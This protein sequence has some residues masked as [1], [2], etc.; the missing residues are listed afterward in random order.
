MNI[1]RIT[2]YLRLREQLTESE[3]QL[4][5][6]FAGLSE[7][8][9]GLLVESLGPV[10]RVAKK[11]ASK[12][13]RATGLA[14]QLSGAAGIQRC[15]ATVDDKPCGEPQGHALHE[16]KSYGNYHPFKSGAAS[17]GGRSRPSRVGESS[18]SFETGKDDASSAA[19]AGSGD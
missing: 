12:S 19:G 10:K 7:T 4:A 1:R 11:K 15:D 8:D 13:K 5:D 2:Q 18:A 9:R 17:V 3:L 14:N 16:D 6:T